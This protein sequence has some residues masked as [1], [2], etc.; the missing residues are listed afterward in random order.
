M[1]KVPLKKTAYSAPKAEV[2]VL[3]G[4]KGRINAYDIILGSVEIDTDQI[5]AY[6]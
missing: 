6:V 5:P 3:M 4:P 2:P 1:I